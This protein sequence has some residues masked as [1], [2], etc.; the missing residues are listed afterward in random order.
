MNT[1]QYLSRYIQN[2]IH[3]Y[4]LLVLI[5][6]GSLLY[7]LNPWSDAPIP[8]QYNSE[9]KA[10]F[11]SQDASPQVSAE[12]QSGTS[13]QSNNT[14]SNPED[15]QGNPQLQALQEQLN[16]QSLDTEVLADI[17]Q[18]ITAADQLIAATDKQLQQQGLIEGAASD[19]NLEQQLALLRQRLD[20]LKN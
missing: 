6:G 16:T 20:Q 13:E 9:G 18:Q 4:G 5:L 17:E 14:S 11:P 10:S 2:E 8:V 15:W 7:M 3:F 12:S 1:S 19:P